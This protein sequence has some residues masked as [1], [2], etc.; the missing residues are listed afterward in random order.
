MLCIAFP[1]QE[2]STYSC[3]DVHVSDTE[4][5]REHRSLFIFVT[6][7]KQLIVNLF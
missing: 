4:Q 2:N 5:A 7:V 1:K 6:M 3:R